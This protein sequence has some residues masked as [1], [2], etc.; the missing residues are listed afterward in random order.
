MA[1]TSAF[2]SGLLARRTVYALSGSS[3]I[4]D[5]RIREIVEFTVKHS[6]SSFNSQSSR[7]VLVLKEEH[8]RVWGLIGDGLKAAIGEEKY[9]SSEARISG[10]A[11][12]YGT[13]LLFED[14]AVVKGLQEKL[15]TYADKFPQWAD[16]AHGILA[17]NL[18][19]QFSTDG[20][21]ANLQ[22]YSPLADDAIKQQYDIPATWELKAQLVFG[23]IEAPAGEKSFAPIEDRV[24]VY[25][26]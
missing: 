21:G 5:A 17:S 14:S 3:P 9:K 8:K 25:G 6:P 18:W 24:K 4:S 19:V 2:Q 7:A 26:A 1:S 16:H 15:P 10:F 13:V 11:A 12:A 23:K 20:L 22:H